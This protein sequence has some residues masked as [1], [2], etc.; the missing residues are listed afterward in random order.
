MPVFSCGGMRY[1]HAWKDVPEAD[2]P[3]KN[4][5]NLEATIHRSLE[6]GINHIETARGYGSSEFQLGKLLPSLPRDSMIVQTKVAPHKDPKQFLATFEESMANLKLDYVDLF[7][8][9]GINNEA[10]LAD[11]MTCLDTAR[12]LQQEGRIRHIGFSTHAHVDT[13]SKAIDTGEFDYVNLHWY[14]IFQDNWPAVLKARQQDMG[15]FIISPSDKGGMLY[16]PTP[17]F[18][19]CAAP[20]TPMAFN[21]LFCL[22][23]EEVHT[24]SIGASRPQDFDA[25]MQAL[26][27][28]D[29]RQQLLEQSETRLLKKMH[30]ATGTDWWEKFTE[31][32]PEWWNAPKKIQLKII[33]WLWSLDQAFGMREFAKFRYG[34][35]GNGGHWFPGEKA[36]DLTEIDWS[37]VLGS[38]PFQDVIPK[39]L[40]QAHEW[41]GAEDRQ[42][43]SESD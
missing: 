18:S 33:L 8:F 27:D 1:Q 41:Y 5:A 19:E 9:H 11:T 4:Q 34:L 32:V 22:N 38:S 37:E 14:W 23:R 21:D 35:L 6:L 13:I 26:N 28:W 20:L 36:A 3:A 12:R 40:Q 17:I 25:H 30:A 24:L 29:N 43:L 39:R 7:A 2:I 42:R 10:V 16:K 15:V 31:G